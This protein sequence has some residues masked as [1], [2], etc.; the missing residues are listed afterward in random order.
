MLKPLV[1]I[2][3]FYWSAGSVGRLRANVLG[4]GLFMRLPFLLCSW[5]DSVWFIIAAAVNYMLF[6]RAGVPAWMEILKKNLPPE[7]R[8]RLFSWSAAVGYGEGAS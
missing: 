4:A 3:S 7:K 5:F 8:S 1:T 2:L 6:Y